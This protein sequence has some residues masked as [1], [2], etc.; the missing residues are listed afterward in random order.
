MAAP[1]ESNNQGKIAD[2]NSEKDLKLSILIATLLMAL[3]VIM[4]SLSEKQILIDARPKAKQR[5]NLYSL[6]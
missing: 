4:E 6:I 1:M 2:E 5:N 3:P